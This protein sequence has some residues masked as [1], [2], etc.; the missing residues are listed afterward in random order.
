MKY[1]D[2]ELA[3]R[4]E[5]AGHPDWIEDD[6][7]GLDIAY[8]GRSGNARIAVGGGIAEFRGINSPVTQ[9]EGLGLNA[10]V[11]EE[12]FERLEE[13]F[14]SRGSAVFIEVSPM[15]D[16]AFIET[17]GRAGLPR[18][19]ILEHVDER[20]RRV[21]TIPVALS[22]FDDTSRRTRG[23]ASLCRNCFT[24]VCGSL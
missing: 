6:A 5:L 11:S 12:E 8:R 20:Y 22:R 23:I 3:R 14:R 24:R 21:R 18:D 15:A 2:L 16:Q 17:L 13:F 7:D 9:A 4:L 19:R 1:V 10:P